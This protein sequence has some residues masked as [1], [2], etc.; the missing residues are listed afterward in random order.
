MAAGN[1]ARVAGPQRRENYHDLYACTATRRARGAQPAGPDGIKKP[2]AYPARGFAM[3]RVQNQRFLRR[4]LA[5]ALVL[6][7]AGNSVLEKESPGQMPV[8]AAK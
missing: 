2:R 3:R 6:D 1:I 4:A 5:G 7:F 8:T